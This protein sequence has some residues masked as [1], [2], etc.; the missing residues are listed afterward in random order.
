M[1]AAK[2][3][4]YFLGPGVQ[5]PFKPETA[6]QTFSLGNMSHFLRK[7]SFP[8]SASAARNKSALA[9]RNVIF[10]TFT[11]RVNHTRKLFEGEHQHGK[12]E[13]EFPWRKASVCDGAVVAYLVLMHDARRRC[14]ARKRGG[15][16]GC[17]RARRWVENMEIEPNKCVA[18]EGE[19]RRGSNEGDEVI[20]CHRAE[21]KKGM[22]A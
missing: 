15:K 21:P 18:Y 2:K 6:D 7:R 14:S 16:L 4:R 1:A 22:V 19:F 17:R 8:L 10:N 5:G 13:K 20:F 11:A 12:S 9:L 3:R